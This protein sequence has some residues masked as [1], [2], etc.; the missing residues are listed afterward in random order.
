MSNDVRSISSTTSMNGPVVASEEHGAAQLLQLAELLFFAYRDFI[1]DPDE[2]LAEYGFGRAH[3]RVV[4]FVS[5]NPGIKVTDLLNILSIT[6]QSL[7][8]IMRQLIEGDF[9]RQ[10]EG[11][12]DR[13]QRLLYL[14]EKGRALAMRLSE[15]QSVRLAKTL[16]A[17]GPDGAEKVRDALYHVVSPHNRPQ[18]NQIVLQNDRIG[19]RS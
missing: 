19:D 16:E 12:Q 17:I 6:K 7:G 2:I 1:S 9:I 8:R 13:R 4:H 15:P 11:R 10:Q 3:H 18:V 14:T 5:R